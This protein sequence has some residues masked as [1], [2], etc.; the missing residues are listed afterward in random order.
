M[1]NKIKITDHHLAP[2][3]RGD[4]DIAAFTLMVCHEGG[5][6]DYAKINFSEDGSNKVYIADNTK[7][8]IAIPE[9]YEERADVAYCGVFWF[10]IFDDEHRIFKSENYHGKADLGLFEKGRSAI[11][12][13]EPIEDEEE[14]T[15]TVYVN[16]YR[17]GRI[18]GEIVEYGG[19]NPC[20][21]ELIAEMQETP[22]VLEICE[23]YSDN[24]GAYGLIWKRED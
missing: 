12:L 17:D 16:Y 13:I 24:G 9:Y 11:V 3:Y 6:I 2:I 22:S 23:G 15:G 21:D 18:Y 10:A 1:E 4:T 20:K 5:K 19:E 8:N 14:E 7:E